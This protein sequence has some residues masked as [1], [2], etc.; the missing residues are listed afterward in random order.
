MKGPSAAISDTANYCTT[1]M[2]QST[3]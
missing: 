1:V 2:L 3:E